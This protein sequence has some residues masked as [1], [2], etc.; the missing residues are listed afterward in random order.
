MML[1]AFNDKF[2]NC[3]DIY[4]HDHHTQLTSLGVE[5]LRSRAGLKN[6]WQWQKAK[7]V[8]V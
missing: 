3:K 5:A 2:S 4:H 1:C 7:D 6:S 8:R